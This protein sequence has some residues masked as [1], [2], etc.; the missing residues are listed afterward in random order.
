MDALI[1]IFCIVNL[2]G[3]IIGIVLP[4]VSESRQNSNL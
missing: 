2:A 3:I 1:A 4:N